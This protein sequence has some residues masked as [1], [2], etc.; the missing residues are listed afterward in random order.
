M[1]TPSAAVDTRGDP[2]CRAVPDAGPGG[3]GGYGYVVFCV[4]AL[5]PSPPML[6]P[7]L[8]GHAAAPDTAS[9]E[10]P[11]VLRAAVL[12]AGAELATA[13]AD[14]TVI[15]ADTRAADYGPE[16]VGTFAGFGA[17]LRV[18]LS[19]GV[20]PAAAA[21]ARLPLAVLVA[22][23]LREQ[24]A[25]AARVRAHVLAHDTEPE[26]AVAA[27]RALRE[28]LD[29]APGPRA[30]LVVADGAATLTLAAPGYLDERAVAFQADLDTALR[31]GDRSALSALDP[32]LCTDLWAPAR[33]AHQALAGL[34]AADP[35]DPAVRTLYQDAPY[36]VGY[37]VSVWRP[38]TAAV[39]G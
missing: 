37:D 33:P 12:A 32:D 35:A 6:V 4:A 34:F 11:A 23:W 36:G 8:C 27:G 1:P 15:G 25:P 29:A 31:A 9:G 18:T 24:V 30:V 7:A 16:T 20:S 22:G 39:S 19:E 5:V 38:A 10:E 3:V 13:A 17:D 14:W 2:V 28:R 26:R 21:D